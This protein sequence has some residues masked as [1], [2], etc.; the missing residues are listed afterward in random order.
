MIT[1]GH[2]RDEDVVKCNHHCSTNHLV[3]NRVIYTQ[4]TGIL[5]SVIPDS[6]PFVLVTYILNVVNI[7]IPFLFDGQSVVY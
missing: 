6:I 4:S 5:Y 3:L 1:V 2:Q 7:R